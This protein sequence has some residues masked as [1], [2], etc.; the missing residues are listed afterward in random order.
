MDLNRDRYVSEN[1]GYRT[2]TVILCMNVRS[3]CRIYFF[4]NQQCLLLVQTVG[5]C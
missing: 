5:V 2:R 4:C 3:A 1:F